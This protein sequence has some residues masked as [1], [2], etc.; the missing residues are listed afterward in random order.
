MLVRC[1]WGWE[2]GAGDGR[3]PGLDVLKAEDRTG[4]WKFC[5]LET[6]VWDRGCGRDIGPMR[7]V[8]FLFCGSYLAEPS[9][10]PDSQ[11]RATALYV[12]MIETRSHDCVLL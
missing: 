7:N 1:V 3:G 6:A 10:M 5:Q 2:K 8:V 12:R 11:S 4:H 9:T